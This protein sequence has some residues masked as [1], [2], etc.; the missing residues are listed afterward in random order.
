MGGGNDEGAMRGEMK[1]EGSRR[2]GRMK[3]KR[4]KER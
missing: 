1:D 3:V 2:G 4:R